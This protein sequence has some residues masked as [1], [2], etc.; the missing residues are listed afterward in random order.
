M[1]SGR[2]L[3]R[4]Q[5]QPS[6]LSLQRLDERLAPAGIAPVVHDD[7]IEFAWPA[8]RVVVD[9]LSNDVG[10]QVGWSVASIT[11]LPESE[12]VYFERE[13]RVVLGGDVNSSPLGDGHASAF[14]SFVRANGE[15]ELR[16]AHIDNWVPTQGRPYGGGNYD[17][18]IRLGE[19]DFSHF[20]PAVFDYRLRGSPADSGMSQTFSV[21]GLTPGTP[22][23]AWIDNT[24]DPG[25]VP[26]ATIAKSFD[27]PKL[28]YFPEYPIGGDLHLFYTVTNAD[29][30]V[31]NVGTITIRPT[32]V[33]APL[34]V[35]DTFVVDN[36]GSELLYPF[37]N[38][39][40]VSAPLDLASIT[41]LSHPQHG[42]ATISHDEYQ[43]YVVYTSAAGYVGEDSLTYFVSD[44]QGRTS[45]PATISISVVESNFPPH[46]NPDS[47]TVHLNQSVQADVLSNDLDF[48]GG[49]EASTLTITK[50][51][52]HGTAAVKLVESVWLIEYVPFTDYL[53]EDYLE[54]TVSD[55]RGRVSA[56]EG[57]LIGVS[58]EPPAAFDDLVS[59]A[60]DAA[61]EIDVLA[62]D[63][64]FDGSLVP[65]SLT[66]S[67][68]PTH[69]TAVVQ[70]GAN[71][72]IVV[73]T[74]NPGYWGLDSF[75]YR[76]T[77]NDGAVS[78]GT[79]QLNSTP[80]AADD[81]ATTDNNS[82]LA[83]DIFGNDV[84][85][86]N[87]I[88]PASFVLVAGPT[89]GGIELM[90]SDSGPAVR[91]TPTRQIPEELVVDDPRD[92]DD[93][94]YTPGHLSLREAIALAN[95]NRG[96][97]DSFSYTINDAGG[98]LSNVAT[99]T[100][101][102]AAGP[103]R[104]I[105]APSLTARRAA[106]LQL[107]RIGD[108][109]QG[110]SA[111]LI[112]NLIEIV[113]P[114]GPRG[115]TLAGPGS[116]GDL[117]HFIV[118]TGGSLKL[119]NLTLTRG[120]TDGNGGAIFVAG[121]ASASL[122]HTTLSGNFAFDHGG[123]IFNLGQ[124]TL[125]DST[126]TGNRAKLGGAIAN[127]SQLEATATKLIDNRATIGGGLYNFGRATLADSTLRRNAATDRGGGFFQDAGE[128]TIQNTT[129]A[130]NSARE[131]GGFFSFGHVELVASNLTANTAKKGGGFYTAYAAFTGTSEGGRVDLTSSTIANNSATQGGGIYNQGA[132]FTSLATI[133]GNRAELGGGI[134]F[135]KSPA[136][137]QSTT[138]ELLGST[139]SANRATHGA[140][141]YLERGD[142]AIVDSTFASNQ[143]TGNGGAIWSSGLIDLTNT[144]LRANSADSGGGL[145]NLG[146]SAQIAGSTISG[147]KA[148]RGAGIYNQGGHVSLAETTVAG[149][150]NGR[151]AS[152][153]GGPTPIG[154]TAPVSSAIDSAVDY[155]VAP[156]DA[157]EYRLTAAHVLQS[158]A[159]G[160]PWTAL[161]EGVVQFARS[162]NGDLYVLNDRQ[163]VHLL[164]LGY[165][166]TLLHN[167]VR[168]MQI[169]D[170]GTLIVV[171]NLNRITMHWGFDRYYVLPEIP[172]GADEF[173]R[174]F[175]SDLEVL[176]AAGMSSG[177]DL[178]APDDLRNDIQDFPAGPAFPLLNDLVLIR[179]V[180]GAPDSPIPDPTNLPERQRDVRSSYNNVRLTKERV[181]ESF[182]APRLIPGVGWVR[183]HHEVFK[184]LIWSAALVREES[185][186]ELNFD[187]VFIRYSHLHRY[188]PGTKPAGASEPSPSAFPLSASSS[189]APQGE[190]PDTSFG[191]PGVNYRRFDDTVVRSLIKIADGTLYRWGGGSDENKAFGSE[192]A[193]SMLY[194]QLPNSLWQA[195]DYVFD[196]AVQPDGTLYTLT[197]RHEVRVFAPGSDHWSIDAQRV[198]FLGMLP[199]GKVFTLGQD[200]VLRSK[201]AGASA[202]TTLA[203]GIQSV[204]IDHG[205]LI[206]LTESGDLLRLKDDAKWTTLDRGVESFAV[207]TSGNLYELNG[208]GELIRFPSSGRSVVLDRG[209]EKF[210]MAPDGSL[211]VLSQGGP[212]KRL[213]PRDHWTVIEA[214][215]L[216][217]SIAPNG[218][219]FL[220]NGNHELLRQKGN[221]PWMKI[222][223]EVQSFQI[224]SDGIV[225]LVDS[226]G[227]T[228][229]YASSGGAGG[230]NFIFGADLAP[231]TQPPSDF[232]VKVVSNLVNQ[233]DI[234]YFP[235]NFDPSVPL[236]YQGDPVAS[237][238]GTPSQR[239]SESPALQFTSHRLPDSSGIPVWGNI[240]FSKSKVVEELGPV[241]LV[242]GI[243]PLQLHHSV[244]YC[245]VYFSQ[246]ETE[247]GHMLVIIDEDHYH[248]PARGF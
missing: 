129:L 51:P 86:D 226:S 165:A 224:F 246:T 213:T 235:T 191:Y 189:P 220:L 96:Y 73:Y 101:E 239:G 24:I 153:F 163:E 207:D 33:R 201:G 171:D 61:I 105:F 83:I 91:Y 29:G 152:D 55:T 233:A 193:P 17:V 103:T 32:L 158:R 184:C 93:G 183:L 150:F 114:T 87:A 9:F 204:T 98:L 26:M 222:W 133:R 54:Y 74:P 22:F 216:D 143:A 21:P 36:D 130:E 237:L 18:F 56:P 215:A 49:I 126:L 106:T 194:R 64:D 53:G 79:V 164:Q 23:I 102:V 10:I 234:Q 113:G 34:A 119:D 136:T 117:R 72:P 77:D 2:S 131:G 168:S 242:P 161:V 52:E 67:S 229:H 99:V 211:Y 5:R 170:Y 112:R 212:L 198:D 227:E 200:H 12:G 89:R 123:A 132:V 173:S 134:F 210:E 230:A 160:K 144:I 30:L 75:R 38:D 214:A 66:I 231:F 181:E 225:Y 236:E 19:S 15:I 223:Q 241:E 221:S 128:T 202:W 63:F 185:A 206:A 188:T 70:P 57:V 180:L 50:A 139:L 81:I 127:L 154:T 140:G 97:T 85:F 107:S 179:N 199:S 41:I 238:I 138:L 243:G 80:Q 31:S 244:F 65:G 203:T 94:I 146:G 197:R 92:I 40:P 71:G 156:R 151:L 248:Y 182:D 141:L 174:A 145:F 137:S 217:F 46:T 16:V 1:S 240:R 45:D 95:S 76:I 155:S 59:V 247:E 196:F 142:A 228:I 82:P 109:S 116:A 28:V 118:A 147:N 6:R 167:G 111:L 100:I 42:V 58:N 192:P 149:N 25:L 27:L 88:V 122:H 8:E 39:K 219:V 159:P 125:A 62:N 37:Q 20:D 135:A 48:D 148:R 13:E 44:E 43:N 187:T 69:G 218:D 169:D 104:I 78:E 186:D 162:P 120:A 47:P 110:N 175:P 84:D 195:I 124:L 208:R 172:A 115:I 205:R 4:K 245:D 157:T 14:A 68:S 121:G 177:H 166:W 7:L 232:E 35:D 90:D 209:V 190:G 178:H 11:W 176:Q 60:S 108:T 3:T